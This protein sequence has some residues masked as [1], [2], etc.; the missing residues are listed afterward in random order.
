MPRKCVR[1]KAGLL[2]PG[3]FFIHF[4]IIGPRNIDRYIGVRP[5]P[6]LSEKSQL[7][8]RFDLTND[9]IAISS[10]GNLFARATRLLSYY[11]LQQHVGDKTD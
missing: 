4:G 9:F 11:K 7:L 3:F 6:D 8:V 10:H 1:Y 2:Q 5:Y